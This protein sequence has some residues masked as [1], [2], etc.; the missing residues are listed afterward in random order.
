MGLTYAMFKLINLFNR[1]RVEIN[2]LIDTSA[3]FMSP[4]RWY[5][6]TSRYAA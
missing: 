4:K 6:A 5:R 3:T 2:A 1:K